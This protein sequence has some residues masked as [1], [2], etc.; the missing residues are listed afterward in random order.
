MSYRPQYAYPPPPP[1]W[2]DEEFEYIFDVADTPALAILP[3][4]RIPLQL[5][6][7]A[8]Y[9]F[10]AFQISGNTGKLLVRFWSP[11]GFI[12]SQVQIENDLAYSAAVG[13]SPVGKLPVPLP[14]EIVCPPGAALLI[15]VASF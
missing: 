10:R 14:D 2:K 15:D 9:R 1:G 13:P 3:S 6:Q 5:Q 7:D 8:E 11:D 4:Y 12:L